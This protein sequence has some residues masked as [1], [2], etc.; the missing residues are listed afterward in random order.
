MLALC[1]LALYT[2]MTICALRESQSVSCA[3]TAS[4]PASCGSVSGK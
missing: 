2:I 1:V 4:R 3:F